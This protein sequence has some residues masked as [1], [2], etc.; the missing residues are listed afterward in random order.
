MSHGLPSIVSNVCALP[1]LVEDGK[2]G[3]VIKPGSVDELTGRLETLI[4]DLPLRKKMGEAARRRFEEKF[5]IDVSNEALLE[6]YK[7]TINN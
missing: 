4:K 6:I 5:L 7:E 2:T 3:F 1:E